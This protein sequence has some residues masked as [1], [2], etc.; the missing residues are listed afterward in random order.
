MPTRKKAGSSVNRAWG[1]GPKKKNPSKKILPKKRKPLPK[2]RKPLAKGKALLKK[3]VSKRK[4]F[5][6]RR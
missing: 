4:S 3:V 1:L 6:K 5:K 2:R